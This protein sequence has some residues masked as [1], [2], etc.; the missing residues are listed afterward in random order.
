MI[1]LDANVLIRL[2]ARESALAPLFGALR[3]GK[4]AGA[5]VLSWHEFITG[6]VSQPHL[7]IVKDFLGPWVTPFDVRAAERGAEL[8]NAIG[9]HRRQRMDCL[10]AAAAIVEAA[11][12]FTLNVADFERFVPFGLELLR[13]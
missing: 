7:K 10:I 5:S 11:R 1:H 4:T 3:Q 9:H 2:P 8:F 6:P 13:E 12:L